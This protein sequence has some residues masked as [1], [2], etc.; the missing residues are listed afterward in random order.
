MAE[1]RNLPLIGF[2][3][4]LLRCLVRAAIDSAEFFE[5]RMRTS[6]IALALIALGFLLHWAVRG[7]AETKDEAYKWIVLVAAPTVLFL[8]GLFL[9]NLFRAPYLI[10]AEE[11][12][13]MQ[14][15][16][17][18]ATAQEVAAEARAQTAEG[19]VKELEQRL[20][21]KGGGKQTPDNNAQIQS[22]IRK[23]LLFPNAAQDSTPPKTLIETLLTDQTPRKLFDVLIQYDENAISAVNLSGPLLRDF[24]H[25]YYQFENDT[26]QLEKDLLGRIG[27]MVV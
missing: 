10:Y 3:N 8:A 7:I 17:G 15:L 21:S 6:L 9:V 20:A 1:V 27:G 24:L 26:D 13:K 25:K 2:G 12:N 11:H 19:R 14:G 18:D 16:I 4:F 5:L 23:V 22:A